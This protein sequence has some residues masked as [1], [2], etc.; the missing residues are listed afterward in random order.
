MY[1]NFDLYVAVNTYNQGIRIFPD[2]FREY[3]HVFPEIFT[4]LLGLF[5]DPWLSFCADIVM[6]VYV[7]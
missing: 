1:L 6:D 7:K 2:I 5:P 3:R 4:H